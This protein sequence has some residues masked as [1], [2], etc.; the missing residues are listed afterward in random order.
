MLLT[1]AVA[2]S[3]VLASCDA[4]PVPFGAVAAWGGWA[5]GTTCESIARAIAIASGV[6]AAGSVESVLALGSADCAASPAADLSPPLRL[7]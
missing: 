5:I 4:A 1:A 6:A 2:A 3:A 7:A